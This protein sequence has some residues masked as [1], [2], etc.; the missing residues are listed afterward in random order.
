MPE[1]PKKD[2][3]DLGIFNVDTLVAETNKEPFR[4]TLDG[5]IRELPHFA[6]VTPRQ[7]L[8]LDSGNMDI[9]GEIAGEDLA[10][11]IMSLPGFAADAVLEQW[12]KHAGNAPGE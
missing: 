9:F 7:A 8:A 6:T 2:K 12:M 10:D 3:V 4:F 11:K 5:E 1:T